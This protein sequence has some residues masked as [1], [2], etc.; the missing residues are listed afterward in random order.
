ME[1]PESMPFA[2]EQVDTQPIEIMHAQ[3]PAEPTTTVSPDMSAEERRKQYSGVKALSKT[4]SFP[5]MTEG[6][7]GSKEV[8][9]EQEKKPTEPTEVKEHCF[10]DTSSSNVS[11]LDH[12]ITNSTY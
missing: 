3:V 12:E 5:G 8:E 9:E 11:I 1:V 10:L 7:Q 6:S 4:L 2:S